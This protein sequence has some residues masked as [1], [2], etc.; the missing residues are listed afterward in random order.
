[1]ILLHTYNRKRI[2]FINYKKK[3][4][5]FKNPLWNNNELLDN[6]Y[7]VFALTLTYTMLAKGFGLVKLHKENHPVH[8]IISLVKS[9]TYE[10]TSVL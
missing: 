8:A 2:L 1:M 3:K 5:K 7:H 4:K 10:L 6:E 9:P